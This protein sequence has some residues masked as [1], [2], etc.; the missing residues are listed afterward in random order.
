[1]SGI[2]TAS[3]GSALPIKQLLLLGAFTLFLHTPF[4]WQPVQGDEVNYLDMAGNVF[5]QPLTP[6]NFR[7][8]FQ[9]REVDVSGHPHPPLNAYLLAG[10]WA[11]R[12]KVSA[13]FFHAAYLVFPLAAAFAAYALAARFTTQPLWAA[14]LVAASP[15]VQV[16]T[17]TMAGAEAPALALQ[18]AGA[19]FFLARRFTPAGVLLSLAG[20]TAL[21]ALALGPILLLEYAVRRVRPPRAAWAAAIAPFLLLGA[22]QV[23]Q[24]VLT[25]R[26][27]LAVLF[28]YATG[29]AY[30]RL[31]LRA[32]G[33]VA[34]VEHLGVLVLFPLLATPAFRPRWPMPLVSVLAGM[35]TAVAVADYPWWERALLAVFV[36]LGLNALLWL[37]DA[38]RPQPFLAW[39]CLAYFAFAAVAFFAGAARYLLPLAAPM[40]VLFVRQAEN[41][42]RLLALALTLSAFAGLNLSFAAYEFSRVYAAVA[43]PPGRTFLVN[44]EWGF[45]YHM[46][47]KGGRAL[48][49]TSRPAPGEWIV[50]SELSLAG[51]YDSPAEA[52]AVPIEAVDL[53]VRSP[54]RLV[55]RFAHSGHSSVT[56]GLLPFSFSRRPLDRIT[57]W[58]TSPFLALDAPWL[59]T[60]FDGRLVYLPTPGTTIRLPL[61]SSWK[62]L[63][64][65][66]FARGAGPA[67]FTVA[68]ASG[69]VVLQQ[70][71]V[72]NGDLWEVHNLPIDGRSEVLLSVSAPAAVRA[73]WGH[74]VAF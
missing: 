51:T 14:L 65:A 24:L 41:R 23:L 4:L 42:P 1:M 63:R 30:G 37:W 36:A 28:G 61:D 53:V 17:N 49:S 40:I 54:V 8:V 18:L 60:Q 7:Y 62:R 29:E 21:Q 66:L 73:G 67:S 45:R 69:R 43:P 20:F 56:F 48:T 25:G 71:V 52:V 39:W 3:N 33:A 13:V 58:R 31:G 15:L 46:V 38:R 34:L 10:L 2:R 57:Y 32:A 59:P 74:L 16:N 44:G 27:P 22:W 68:E 50:S 6:L 35:V 64:V 70:S 47:E 9:G 26:L 11:L 5:R 72:V 12:G 19:A 55:D